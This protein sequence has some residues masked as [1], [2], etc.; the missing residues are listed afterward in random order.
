MVEA[1]RVSLTA[2]EPEV[3]ETPSESGKGQK[4]ARCPTCRVAVW[5]H[6][7][8]AGPRVSFVRVGTL[9]APDHLPPDIHIFTRSK[10]S[11]VHLAADVPAVP[12]YYDREDYWPAI[13]LAR[14]RVLLAQIRVDDL[15]GPAIRALLE[16]HLSNMAQLSPPESMHAL[17][18]DALRQ[19]DV[20]FWSL[21]SGA[22]LLGCGALKQL[23]P[24]HG[25]IKSMRT[26]MAFRGQGVA[27]RLL[28]H[29]VN[30]ARGRGYHMLS[31]ETGSMAAFEPARRL[32]QD[33]GFAACAPFADYVD[34]PHSV[35]M[36]RVP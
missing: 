19:P 14:R 15:S 12:E 11:W 13:S 22:D 29:I 27:R 2:G 30:E 17:D 25:E 32:Y 21:W 9:D 10:Q 33:V 35:F 4:I 7:A 34:D 20:T 8:G 28:G 18:I 23:D 36:Q 6:Y 16:E 31:L 3:V 1:D 5:S 24:Q 26:A